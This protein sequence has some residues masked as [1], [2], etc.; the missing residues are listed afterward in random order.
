MS[1]KENKKEE[2][3]AID[4][5]FYIIDIIKKI[6]NGFYF[7]IK[8]DKSLNELT[9]KE[10]LKVNLSLFSVLSL[11]LAIELYQMKDE[12][13]K[14]KIYMTIIISIIIYTFFAYIAVNIPINLIILIPLWYL[15]F[16][17]SNKIIDVIIEELK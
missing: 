5:I 4:Y 7:I 1:T 14:N 11:Y 3:F 15:I 16:L 13:D 17:N 8:T 6:I 2:T 9:K 12:Q 10:R